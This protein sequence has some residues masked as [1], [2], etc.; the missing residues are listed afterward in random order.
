[1]VG[2]KVSTFKQILY[3]TAIIA[4]TLI[5]L[6]LRLRAVE[7]L[8]IDYDEDDYLHDA[9]SYA[10]A[11]KTGDIQAVVDFNHDVH[12]PLAKLVYSLSLLTL[13]EQEPIDPPSFS[14]PIASSLPQPQL[15]IL[16]TSSAVLGTL[17]VLVLAVLNPLAG[18]F[19][20]INT[21]HIKYTSQ[22]MLE[23]LPSLTSALV[24]LF[25]IKSKK[26]FNFWMILSSIAFGFTLASKYTYAVVG[27]VIALDMFLSIRTSEQDGIMNSLK[28][29]LPKIFVWGL[30]SL[31]TFF[32]VNPYLWNDTFSRFAESIFFHSEYAQSDHVQQAGFPFWQPLIWL[33]SS[34]QWHPGVFIV[35]IDVLFAIFA[36]FGFKNT[37]K[38]FRVLALWLAIA[39]LVLLVWPTKWAQYILILL[40]PLSYTAARGFINGVWNPSI[41]F[42]KRIFKT[43]HKVRKLIPTRRMMQDL[44][45]A[46]PW[47][48]PGIIILG[49]IALYPMIFQSGMALTDFSSGAIRDGLN[50]GIWREVRLGI[51]GQVE[52][53][54]VEMFRR[55][56]SKEVH[57]AGVSMLL[58]M[59]SGGGTVFLVFSVIWT[60]ISIL[61]QTT[62][63]VTAAVLL[64][65]REVRFAGWWRALF[66]LPWA[67]P[68]FVGALMWSQLFDPRFGWI[69]LAAKTWSQT[70]DYPG[71]LNFAYLWQDNPTYAFIILLITATWYGFPFMMLA[72]TAGLKMMPT[73]VNDAAAIDGASGLQKLRLVTL[74]LLMPL[75]IPAILIRGI[76]AFNQFYI[77]YVLQP[78]FP[79]ATLSIVSFFYFDQAGLYAVSAAVNIFT[80]LVL[81]IFI[82]WFNRWSRASEGVT[83]A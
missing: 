78:P 64:N 45:R 82:L 26:S 33:T 41:R 2:K 56:T 5:A 69:N 76:F 65:R 80:V 30:L 21:W 55:S 40:F 36:I 10:Y 52:P 16:R 79:L 4:V 7:L 77:F 22:V 49:A 62:L 58:Q 37:W 9:Q 60:S 15:T 74:P 25:Y 8:P 47:L 29:W 71:A 20:A 32:I 68:E 34:V 27:I 39:L 67:I 42:I 1:M 43:E 12:P 63:G 14:A 13:P 18:L 61:L 23:A 3:I 59:I 35:S 57:Y 48:L 28:Q 75:L 24:V 73:E 53:V 81:I 19:L 17:E 83:Y 11:L 38:R 51:T 46:L 72:A 44:S 50:G 6:F 70:A 54:T 66:V 31:A